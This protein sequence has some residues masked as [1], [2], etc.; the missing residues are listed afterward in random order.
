MYCKMMTLTDTGLCVAFRDMR[1]LALEF[2]SKNEK[3]SRKSGEFFLP[4][5]Y[6]L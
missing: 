4:V 6:R 2:I 1:I 3:W 5:L